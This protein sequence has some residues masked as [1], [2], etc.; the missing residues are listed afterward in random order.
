[1]CRNRGER[2]AS[3]LD[4]LYIKIAEIWSKG[5]ANMKKLK[6][7]V[8]IIISAFALYW[9][10]SVAVCEYNTYKYGEIFRN[11]KIHDIGGEGYLDDCNI[12]V[13]NYNNDY[14]KVYAVFEN[15]LN[16]VGLLYYFIKNDNGN[17]VFDYYDAVY[18]KRGSADGYIWPYIR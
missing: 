18:S 13:L 11:T 12:K 2:L 9:I 10:C 4:S 1:M 3:K 7:A 17:W 6:I 15:E 8:L 16:E 14:A 5:S